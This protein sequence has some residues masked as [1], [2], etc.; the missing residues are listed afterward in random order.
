M[1]K[2]ESQ[3]RFHFIVNVVM[4]LSIILSSIL[5]S[6]AT[7]TSPKENSNRLLL[8][9]KRAYDFGFYNQA[10]DKFNDAINK[11]ER[12][13][14]AYAYRAATKLAL[15]EISSAMNDV[16]IAEENNY[17][18]VFIKTIKAQIFQTEFEK[19]NDEEISELESLLDELVEAKPDNYD[20]R[21]W[22]GSY[23]FNQNKFE[24]TIEDLKGFTSRADA[25]LFTGSSYFQLGEYELAI[26]TLEKAN[27]LSPNNDSILQQLVIS[28]F[29]QE[30]FEK[31]LEYQIQLVDI[32]KNDAI[33]FKDLG[34]LYVL[35]NNFILALESYEKAL[36]FSPEDEELYYQIGVLSYENNEFDKAVTAFTE[37]INLNPDWEE[38][39]LN[40]ATAYL[41]LEEYEFAYQDYI[42]CLEF[43]PESIELLQKVSELDIFLGRIDESIEHFGKLIE[44]D[45]ENIQ[46]L[47]THAYLV[48][49]NQIEKCSMVESEL[50][51]IIEI[52][53]SQTIPYHYLGLCE[54]SKG[55]DEIAAN[56][57][58]LALAGLPETIDSLYFLAFL[59]YE[60]EDYESALN[61]INELESYTSEYALGYF[62]KGNVE[63]ELAHF[64]AAIEDYAIA[65]ENNINV[66]IAS[67]NQG[68]AF[69]NLGELIEAERCFIA[70]LALANDEGQTDLAINIQ[71]ALDTLYEHPD[72]IE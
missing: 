31:A 61:K 18:D 27:G 21:L 9:G 58:T 38:A 24:K 36:E 43:E 8:S 33:V 65:I 23:Y 41:S 63:L 44:K 32:V 29:S 46:F 59:D 13:Y 55:N 4:L 68:V 48:I 17:D 28:Y 37:S 69:F 56:Y 10:L 35:N 30:N 3:N 22:R 71:N 52:D 15:G 20:Y 67:F 42:K 64:E 62:L 53:E 6:L 57:W 54:Y 51:K 60:N 19:L 47:F 12:N 14:E 45:P 72:W 2:N 5:P 1:L 66:L 26:E 11:Y 16:L 25:M 40:R 49:T 70:A 50:E 39:Y 34:M 7:I